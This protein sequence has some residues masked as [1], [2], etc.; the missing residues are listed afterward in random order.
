MA[1][2]L[3]FGEWVCSVQPERCGCFRKVYPREAQ[4]RDGNQVSF[5]NPNGKQV[6]SFPPDLSVYLSCIR[7]FCYLF[8]VRVSKLFRSYRVSGWWE[9]IWVARVQGLCDGR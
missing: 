7:L 6:T 4:R 2:T 3:P 8:A 5:T 9:E 1:T